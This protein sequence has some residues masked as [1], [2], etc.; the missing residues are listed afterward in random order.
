MGVREQCDTLDFRFVN[1]LLF[2]ALAF[3]CLVVGASGSEAVNRNLLT[4]VVDTL[5]DDGVCAR[6]GG[7]LKF[8]W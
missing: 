4:A 5:F 3:E 1:A 2:H 6:H 7:Q 8:E